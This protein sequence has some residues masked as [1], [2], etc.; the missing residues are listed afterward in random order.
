M[1]LW[2]LLCFAFCV[3]LLAWL[4]GWGGIALPRRPVMPVRQ[5]G[6]LGILVAAL[7]VVLLVG[8]PGLIWMLRDHH[9]L[10]GFAEQPLAPADPKLAALLRG[11]QLAPPPPLPP[12]VF[13]TAEVELL[14]PALS[15]ADRRWEG[16]DPDFRQRLLLVFKL[17]RERHGYELV[18]IEG[19]RSPERQA[20][21]AA[22][23]P[24]VTRAGA[25]QSWHQYGLAADCAFLRDGRL[26]ISERDPWAL[27]GY[28]LY[29]ELAEAVGLRWG[30]RWKLMDLGHVEQPRPASKADRVQT[31]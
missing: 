28:R 8:P 20:M 10:E 16:L 13:A 7:A 1:I 19:Y 14:R 30:G 5:P 25:W 17:M 23:G 22:L 21:L 3:V 4:A 26:V 6:R 24:H 11:E 12:E 2:L 31:P 27:R 29:G 9:R 18:L 15:S